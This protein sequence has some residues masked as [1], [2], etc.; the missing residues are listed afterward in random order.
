MTTRYNIESTITIEKNWSRDEV[1]G[2]LQIAMGS[3][4]IVDSLKVS[5][6]VKEDGARLNRDM[7]I[8]A[9]NNVAGKLTK[10]EEELRKKGWNENTLKTRA[11]H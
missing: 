7:Q 6:Q 1:I 10:E 4:G 9:G 3:V 5:I 8:A 2:K 11:G